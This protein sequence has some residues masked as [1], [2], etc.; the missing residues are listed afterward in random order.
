MLCFS[1]F[2]CFL[3]LILGMHLVS[4]PGLDKLCEGSQVD[5]T[6]VVWK[7]SLMIRDVS[8]VEEISLV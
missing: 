5:A 4:H 1:I 2:L 3:V 6:V 7:G 8:F